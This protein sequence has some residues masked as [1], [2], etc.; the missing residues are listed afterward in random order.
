MTPDTQLPPMPKHNPENARIKH[1]YF[2]FLREARGRSN[3][4]V[5]A[6]AK[7]LSRFEVDTRFRP[8]KAFHHQQA[9]AFKRRLA[10]QTNVRTGKPLSKATLLSTLAHLK[11]FFIWLA[12]QRIYKSRISYTDA[13]YFHLSEQD[14]RIA[15]ARLEKPVPTLEQIRH[16][17]ATMP[18]GD[19]IQRRDR[20]V[21]ALILL[22]GARDGAV[23]SLKLKHL[24][25]AGKRVVHDAR[26]VT[27]KA[28]KTFIA[29][30]LPVGDG[31]EEIVRE[32]ADYLTT[33]LHWAP[34]D[35]LFPATGR[36]LG[37]D[38][39]FR[40]AGL[41]RKHWTSA[42]PIRGIFRHAFSAA[43]LPYYTPH[44]VRH[45]LAA[46][47]EKHCRTPEEFKAWSQS[48]G[49][50][51]VLTTFMSYGK[52]DARR[53]AELIHA[54]GQPKKSKEEALNKIAQLAEE[55]RRGD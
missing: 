37:P 23:K 2:Q 25:L 38:R 6:V 12:G 29:N 53:Q 13:S 49:H 3:A 54:L 50:S 41:E 51:R 8:F 52:V 4:S 36:E 28:R 21:V 9:I 31:T 14:E 55:L 20:A 42:G 1:S 22:T 43:H 24:D 10:E 40:A 32:W 19:A 39:R 11:E 45:M 46:L 44:Q 26:E 18:A 47:A 35:P 30:F 34:D 48:L 27:T 16:V 5:D 33:D 17:I 15:R 7:A